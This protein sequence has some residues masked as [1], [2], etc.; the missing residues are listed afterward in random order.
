VLQLVDEY[1]VDGVIHF[2]ST[3]C[4]HANAS[5]RLIEDALA[6]RNIPFLILGG[7]MSDMR[8]YSAEKTRSFLETFIEVM[9]VRK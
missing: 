9:T 1:A 3:A 7:D 6:I 5:F 2:S 8:A 4:R